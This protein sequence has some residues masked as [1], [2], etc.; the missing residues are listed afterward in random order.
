MAVTWLIGN[1]ARFALLG[2]A[3]CE[4][5]LLRPK[6]DSGNILLVLGGSVDLG[7]LGMDVGRCCYRH[8]VAPSWRR[9]GVPHNFKHVAKRGLA[10][11]LYLLKKGLSALVERAA[12]ATS[13]LKAVGHA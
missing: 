5:L 1:K 8:R 13:C 10:S 2:I 6:P 3:V 4:P 11:C 9:S 7:Q 12:G